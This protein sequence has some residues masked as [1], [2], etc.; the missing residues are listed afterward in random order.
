MNATTTL[1]GDLFRALKGGASNFGKSSLHSPYSRQTADM[2]LRPGIVTAYDFVTHPLGN[3]Y[4]EARSYAS[5]QAPSVLQALASYQLGG[6]LDPKSNVALNLVPTG[7]LLV[8]VYSDPARSPAA[9]APF[10]NITSYQTVIA[11][12]NGS[13][14]GLVQAGVANFPSEPQR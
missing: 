7:S 1:N 14:S 4:F 13:F 8:M 9:F 10:Y 3:V 12:T 11:P 5:D 6:Q 2:I